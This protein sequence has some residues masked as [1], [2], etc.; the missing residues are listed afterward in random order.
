[1]SVAL[2]NQKVTEAITAQEG[3]DFDT[4]LTKLRSAAMLIAAKPDTVFDGE[5]LIWDRENIRLLINEVRRAKSGSR[6]IVQQP[7]SRFSRSDC[8]DC[9][10]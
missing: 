2:I 4:A 9:C 8:G 3:G 5:E 6:G 7:V 10:E 1:M